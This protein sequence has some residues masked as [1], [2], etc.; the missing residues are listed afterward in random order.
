MDRS[1]IRK[2]RGLGRGAGVAVAAGGTAGHTAEGAGDGAFAVQG[3]GEDLEPD[4]T[5]AGR[6]LLLPSSLPA[7]PA[8]TT[9]AGVG[10]PGVPQRPVRRVVEVQP[11][12]PALVCRPGLACTGFAARVVAVA[13]FHGVTVTVASTLPLQQ[14]PTNWADHVQE[15]GLHEPAG[16]ALPAAIQAPPRISAG[17]TGATPR[18]PTLRPAATAASRRFRQA[19]LAQPGQH[20]GQVV[21]SHVAF[22]AGP[23]V[24]VPGWEVRGRGETVPPHPPGP[25]AVALSRRAES[26]RQVSNLPIEGKLKTCRHSFVRQLFANVDGQSL[27]G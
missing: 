2:L 7:V 27:A 24:R 15:N 11:A 9:A 14:P 8:G 21:G 25:L 10:T 6:A 16:L 5:A 26:W 17:Q 13:W 12:Q 1:R 19:R 20:P 3:T 23:V 22:S 4:D 18:L